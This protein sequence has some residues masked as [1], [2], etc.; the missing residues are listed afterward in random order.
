MHRMIVFLCTIVLSMTLTYSVGNASKGEDDK[1]N[2][3]GILNT[4]REMMTPEKVDEKG[5]PI[6][7]G[8]NQIKIQEKP[9]RKWSA[10]IRHKWLRNASPR[11]G[12]TNTKIPIERDTSGTY[13][14]IYNS[15][16]KT[17]LPFYLS[18]R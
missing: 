2:T 3:S 18:A 16:L 5:Q 6:H 12:E 11:R 9:K 7:S 10:K 15:Q 13:E 14:E 1:Y 8:P 4:K 17:G